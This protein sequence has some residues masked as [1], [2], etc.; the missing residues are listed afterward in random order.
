MTECFQDIDAEMRS[1]HSDA[2]MKTLT[3]SEVSDIAYVVLKEKAE[4]NGRSL[5]AQVLWLE[6]A[7]LQKKR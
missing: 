2:M 4:T 7:G 5:Q 3:V 6:Q 1:C